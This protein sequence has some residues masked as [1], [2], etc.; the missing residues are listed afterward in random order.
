MAGSGTSP[1]LDPVSSA[2][3]QQRMLLGQRLRGGASWFYWI[4]GLSVINSIIVFSGSHWHFLAG[5]GITD[6]ITYMAHKAGSAGTAL[7]IIF[8]A[9]AM[10]LFVL[11]GVFAHKRHTWAFLVGMTVYGLDALILLLGPDW[12]SIAF[13]AFALFQM[14]KGMQAGFELTELER[15]TV[16]TIVAT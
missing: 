16:Q 5:L 2:Q 7:A 15:G 12:F 11:F 4:T 8:N 14:F 10:A 13:H 6:V 9:F 1:S 3:I